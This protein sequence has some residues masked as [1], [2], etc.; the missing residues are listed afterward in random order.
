MKKKRIFKWFSI[1]DIAFLLLCG[2]IAAV[3]FWMAFRPTTEKPK[4]SEM[5]REE[6]L[7]FVASNGIK[8]P[9]TLNHELT[10]GY[11]VEEMIILAE[12]RPELYMGSYS[13]TMTVYLGECIRK[14]VN[15]YYGI[16]YDNYRIVWDPSFFENSVPGD[17]YNY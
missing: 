4:L 1:A 7:E 5:S 9:D 11:L 14:A 6:M 15:E 8:I 10:I 13:A 16:H 3:C 12:E 17:E 2:A